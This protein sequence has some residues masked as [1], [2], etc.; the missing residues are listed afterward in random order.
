MTVVRY[1]EIKLVRIGIFL[2]KI[3]K[4]GNRIIHV[5]QD[6]TSIMKVCMDFNFN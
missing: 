1:N 6:Y 3:D 5:V 2:F 4:F